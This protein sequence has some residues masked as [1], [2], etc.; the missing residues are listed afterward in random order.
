MKPR[1]CAIVGYALAGMHFNGISMRHTSDTFHVC[2][3]VINLSTARP[4]SAMRNG[5][6]Q[7]KS[8]VGNGAEAK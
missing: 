3:E 5:D 4:K 2:Y 7:S 8:E 6:R 1:R